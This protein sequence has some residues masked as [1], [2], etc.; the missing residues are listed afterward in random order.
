MVT[1]P[2][3]APNIIENMIATGADNPNSHSNAK[4][5]T[6]NATAKRTMLSG[7]M[8]RAKMNSHSRDATCEGPNSVPIEHR[9]AGVDAGALEDREQM[10]R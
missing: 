2:F 6:S 10:G 7:W 5:S 3:A 8:L 9:R 1:R 4:A